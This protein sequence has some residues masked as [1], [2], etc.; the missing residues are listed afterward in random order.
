MTIEEILHRIVRAHLV[1]I[2]VCVLLALSAAVALDAR[3]P[4]SY[5]AQVRLQ[6]LS[7]APTSPTE[8]DALG[9]GVLAL[10]TSPTLVQG[11]LQD[12]G[13]PASQSDAADVAGHRVTARRLGE[14]AIVELAVMDPD[15]TSAARTVTALAARVVTFMNSANRHEYETQLASIDRRRADASARVGRLQA[16]LLRARGPRNRGNVTALLGAAQASL[17]QAESERATLVLSDVNR[18]VVTPIDT[19][20]PTVEQVP[21]TL[22]PR[23]ALALLLGLLLGLTLAVLRETLSPR[24]AGIRALARALDAPLLGSTGQSSAALANTLTFAARRQGVETL[25][26]VGVDERDEKAAGVLLEAMP[27]LWSPELIETDAEVAGARPSARP[28][29]RPSARPTARPTVRAVDHPVAEPAGAP[30][31]AGAGAGQAAPVALSWPL[32]FT[33]RFGVTSAEERSAGVVV[34]SAGNAPRADLDAVQDMLRAIRWPVV[35]I[36][37]VERRA[38]WAKK[39]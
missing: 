23:L 4:T 26:L 35:G 22:V 33:N 31:N 13:L 30:D 15:P 12:A 38:V 29:A 5:L 20:E 10:A 17:T 11:A 9:S 6:T 34:V 2:T 7:T 28:T 27:R 24:L 1:T 8:A 3:T 39:S 32:R 36:V 16:Q 25:V 18:D 19:A 37:E 21:S 14:S